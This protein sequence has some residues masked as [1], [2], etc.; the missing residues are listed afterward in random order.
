MKKSVIAF[1]IAATAG[2]A[3]AAPHQ[4]A[5]QPGGK[6]AHMRKFAEK[7]GLTDA[8]KAQIKAIH[9][10]DR[11]QNKQLYADFRARRQE[12][13]QLKQANDPRAEDLKVALKAMHEQIREAR[14]ATREQVLNVL[15]PEQRA[16]LDQWRA[17]RKNRG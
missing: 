6:A 17:R 2:V 16:Q 1:A 13:R 5:R 7:L 9:Q 8:Q 10:A 11:E 12:F 3:F 4:G 14:K 15:T